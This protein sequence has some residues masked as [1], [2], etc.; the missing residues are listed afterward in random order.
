MGYLFWL[1]PTSTSVL[2]LLL[3]LVVV[4]LFL[5][6]FCFLLK[7]FTHPQCT[8][9]TAQFLWNT[10][11]KDMVYP[12][13]SREM[14]PNLQWTHVFEVCLLYSQCI[15]LLRDTIDRPWFTDWQWRSHSRDRSTSQYEIYVQLW[16]L[17]FLQDVVVRA[18]STYVSKLYQNCTLI[19]T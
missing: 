15:Q 12:E 11:F 4:L 16:T 18:T 19:C 14:C 13:N 8:K 3:L 9:I 6:C 5:F 7:P 2:L 17:Q 10:N 1:H